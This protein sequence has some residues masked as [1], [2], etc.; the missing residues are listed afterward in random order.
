VIRA[1]L[2]LRPPTVIDYYS[3]AVDVSTC[4]AG[5]VV[6]S[7]AWQSS[8]QLAQRKPSPSRTRRSLSSVIVNSGRA[9]GGRASAMRSSSSSGRVGSA[10]WLT[11][12]FDGTTAEELHGYA[13]W[14]RSHW[15][16]SSRSSPAPVGSAPSIP[17][18]PSPR[19]PGICNTSTVS[20]SASCGTH[21]CRRLLRHGLRDR[22]S[23]NGPASSTYCAARLRYGWPL[24]FGLTAAAAVT[25]RVPQLRL[26]VLG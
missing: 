8:R 25:A 21:W 3:R 10:L 23:A 16:C 20:G 22:R 1:H 11:R 15:R 24:V 5:T 9:S 17:G 13:F 18:R 19:P 4:R 7:A 26:G 6:P 14:G 2:L 12:K